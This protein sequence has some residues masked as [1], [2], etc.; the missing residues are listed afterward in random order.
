MT[1][2]LYPTKNRSG[3]D[4]H[5]LRRRDSK[6]FEN[7]VIHCFPDAPKKVINDN[8]HEITIIRTLAPIRQETPVTKFW[9]EMLYHGKIHFKSSLAKWRPTRKWFESSRPVEQKW[10]FR[11]E[12]KFLCKKVQAP[13]GSNLYRHA[14]QT[15]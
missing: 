10:Q 8:Q 7:Q 11:E 14:K 3:K 2:T 13:K 5:Q 12:N 15:Q 4:V 9:S 1:T 6:F